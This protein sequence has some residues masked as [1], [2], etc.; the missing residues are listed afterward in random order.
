MPPLAHIPPALLAAATA[1][2]PADRI[3]HGV[4]AA[5]L[6]LFLAH[7]AASL[8]TR[9]LL[10]R[11]GRTWRDVYRALR[12][13]TNRFKLTQKARIRE[14][15]MKDAEVQEAMLAHARETGA[16][17]AE[18]ERKVR[19]YLDEIIPAFDLVSYYRVGLPIARLLLSLIYKLVSWKDDLPDT[20]RLHAGNAVVYLFNHRSNAD[21]VFAAFALTDRVA[22]SYAVGEWARVWPLESL[23]KS[24]GSYFVRRGFKEKMYHEVLRRYVQLITLRGV[25]QGI[26]LE[27]GLSRDGRFRE[28][29]VG[30]LD[31]ILQCA[32]DPR[33]LEGP[34]A[35]RAALG[36]ADLVFVPGCVNYDRVLEDRSLTAEA[37]GKKPERS[38]WKMAKRTA[39][40]LFRGSMKLALR[41]TRKH[42]YAALRLGKPVSFREWVARE[43][44]G[45]LDGTREERA[46]H[47]QRFAREVM[48]EVARLMPV[49]SVAL[50]ATVF[51][52]E[53]AA[54]TRE[55]VVARVA[56]LRR[57]VEAAGARLVR[58]DKTDAEHADYALLLLETRGTVLREEDGAGPPRFRLKGEDRAIARYY[59]YSIAH[60]LGAPIWPAEAKAKARA[61]DEAERRAS[62]DAAR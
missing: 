49:T 6:A 56:D 2:T 45:A 47:V 3:A 53:T 30:L 43:G 22:I 16:S 54:L 50:A 29:K 15:L 36:F 59:A 17:L 62:L 20:R 58:A 51:A 12:I 40:V 21:F 38:L 18:A 60:F 34:E 57:R 5:L 27:G 37:A 4:L 11:Y 28:P 24:F 48:T 25:P 39:K 33:F 23:F 7:Q 19:I 46:P 52:E 42:G 26:F 10:R 9:L 41:R 14:D 32:R 1:L 35:S 61:V 55:E 44:R 31:H 13:R 8:A